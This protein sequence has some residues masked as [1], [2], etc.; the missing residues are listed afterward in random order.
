[1]ERVEEWVRLGS[2]PNADKKPCIYVERV[3]EWIHYPPSFKGLHV[4]LVLITFT[5]LLLIAS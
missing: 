5:M 3:E 1:M 2:N 4:V